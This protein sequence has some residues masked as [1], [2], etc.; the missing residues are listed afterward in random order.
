M[1]R[2][3]ARQIMAAGAGVAATVSEPMMAAIVV[4]V[5]VV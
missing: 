2:L 3:E 4:V 1:P 5:V